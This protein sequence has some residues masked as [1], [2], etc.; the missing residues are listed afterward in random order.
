MSIW[1]VVICP[2]RREYFDPGT[3][4]E[5]QMVAAGEQLAALMCRDWRGSPIHVETDWD[6]DETDTT[7]WVNRY[8][9]P[10]AEQGPT[11]PRAELAAEV[12]R[13]RA[14]IKTAEKS[15]L[16]EP[17]ATTSSSGCPWCNEASWDRHRD[18]CPAFWPNG[19]VR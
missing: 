19:V 13:L 2:S 6:D 18:D 10:P 4:R 11:I 3:A 15:G 9:A 8:V 14:I 16:N 17:W 12:D 7:G 1:Y 5:Y